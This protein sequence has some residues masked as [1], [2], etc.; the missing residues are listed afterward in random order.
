MLGRRALLALFT[1]A[2]GA[3]A[4]G[5]SPKEVVGALRGMP[6]PLGDPWDY[7]DEETEGVVAI[8]ERLPTKE[9]PLTKMMKEAAKNRRRAVWRAFS[10]HERRKDASAD[11]MP[12]HIASKRSWSDVYKASVWAA[13]QAELDRLRD[14]LHHESVTSKL[15][16]LLGIPVDLKD[17]GRP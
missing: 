8:P 9:D 15:A 14:A 13:E 3:A 7:G 1:G 6:L 17:E 10:E 12:A 11:R 4:A 5:V 16:D 2:T